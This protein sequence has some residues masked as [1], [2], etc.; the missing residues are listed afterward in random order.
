MEQTIQELLSYD[1][2]KEIYDKLISASKD[3]NFKLGGYQCTVPLRNS[4]FELI[5]IDQDT[6]CILFKIDFIDENKLKFEKAYGYK[7][8]KNNL[9]QILK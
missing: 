7:M 4:A 5:L 6:L 9:E 1:I 8:N 3:E 2:R